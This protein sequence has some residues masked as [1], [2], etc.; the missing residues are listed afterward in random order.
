MTSCRVWSANES[1]EIFCGNGH[2]VGTE[3]LCDDG[4]DGKA[5]IGNDN[6]GAGLHE[7]VPDELNNF[8]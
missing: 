1:S 6:V 2:Q 8:I 3:E 4:I 5:V 7:G